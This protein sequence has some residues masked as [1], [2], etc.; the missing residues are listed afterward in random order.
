MNFLDTWQ[1]IINKLR[2]NSEEL[3][4]KTT[5][6]EAGKYGVVPGVPPLIWV[7]LEAG[8]GTNSASGKFSGRT[9]VGIISCCAGAKKDAMTGISDSL[10]LTEK[11]EKIIEKIPGIIFGENPISLDT[12]F[13]DKIAHSLEFTVRYSRG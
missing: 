3:G 2:E 6:I 4:V 11:C 7:Y 1:N 12:V 13:S 8:K 10:T 5:A 9:A